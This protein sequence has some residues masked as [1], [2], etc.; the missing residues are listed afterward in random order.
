MRFFLL[1]LATAIAALAALGLLSCVGIESAKSEN[2]S[3]WEED[4][5]EQVG[6]YEEVDTVP[7]MEMDESSKYEEAEEEYNNLEDYE[8][9][10]EDIELEGGEQ[11][12][13]AY[14]NQ[15]KSNEIEE[16]KSWIQGSWYY[17]SIIM[18][19]KYTSIITISGDKITAKTNG[20]LDYSGPYEIDLDY[21]GLRYNYKTGKHD[22][23]EKF[24]RIH[25]RDIYII[26]DK[27]RRRLKVD[28][29]NYYNRL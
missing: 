24:S 18:G 16:I 7:P 8:E 25:F 20:E 11:N 15:S 21:E 22:I 12:G 2:E 17:S 4:S 9:D 19:T 26:I 5:T 13:Q 1:S 10:Y 3:I 14:G 29:N 6:Y 27:E 23:L 28:E